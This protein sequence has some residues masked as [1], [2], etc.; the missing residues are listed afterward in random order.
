M[1]EII[2]NFKKLDGTLVNDVEKYVKEWTKLNPY[3]KVIIGCDSQTHSRRIKYSIIICMHKIDIM[4][5]GHGAHLLI[6]NIWTKRMNSSQI[7]GMDSKLWKEAE[8]ALQTAELVN[9]KDDYF[10]KKIEVH[11]DYN[12]IAEA[13][14]HAN[15]SHRLYASG[16]GLLQSY[17]Y[18]NV[19]GKPAAI[20]SANCAD[21]FAKGGH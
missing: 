5:V 13:N 1:E 7:D 6:C 3:G 17:G 15:L 2:L 10:K 20:I 12:S 11:L 8:L 14:S 19:K 21:H 16:L 18:D 4:Q 9:G